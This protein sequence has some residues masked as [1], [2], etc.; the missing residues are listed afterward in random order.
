M[1]PRTGAWLLILVVVPLHL[2]TTGLLLW[3]VWGGLK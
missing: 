1:S 2:I 3:V